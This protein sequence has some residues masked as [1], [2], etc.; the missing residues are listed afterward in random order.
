M[1]R[2]RRRLPAA[3]AVTFALL[4][5]AAM[6]A[7]LATALESTDTTL[8]D[9][10]TLDDASPSPTDDGTLE[11]T[12]DDTET[13]DDTVDTV[14]DTVEETSDEL[15]AS[16]QEVLAPEEEPSE[17]PSD[18]ASD[19]TADDEGTEDEPADE[20]AAS[21]EGSDT[22]G[23]GDSTQQ[24]DRPSDPAAEREARLRAAAAVLARYQNDLSPSTME[25][26]YG[27]PYGGDAPAWRMPVRSV[28]GIDPASVFIAGPDL[29]APLFAGLDY[30]RSHGQRS[31]HD[32]LERL[33]DAGADLSTAAKVLSPF[34]VVGPATYTDDWHYPRDG[35]DRLHK[36]T[37]IFAQRGTPVVASADGVIGRIGVNQ[38]L[39]GNTIGLY[40]DDGTYFYYAH[41]DA[42]A[43]D[44]RFNL[45]VE[46]GDIIGFVGDSGNAAGTPPHLHF[47]IH[48]DNGAAIPPVDHLDGWLEE[49]RAK[50]LLVRDRSG[51][52][53]LP[54]M[55][56]PPAAGSA[57]VAEGSASVGEGSA[58]ASSAEQL[59]TRR[60]GYTGHEDSSQSIAVFLALTGVAWYFLRRRSVFAGAGA[61]SGSEPDVVPAVPDVPDVLEPVLTVQDIVQAGEDQRSVSGERDVLQPVLA[62]RGAEPQ[63]QPRQDDGAR[64]D[65]LADI[66]S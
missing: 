16:T 35:G 40:A 32:I 50:V 30:D 39:G 66:L 22:E 52:D 46:Q 27:A 5:V 63:P 41:L 65:V 55:V 31:T 37:D 64:R 54:T 36:G 8:V 15:E 53:G 24:A 51:L 1:N 3:A 21:D 49:A 44:V 19:E 42:F 18:E 47:Q 17:D 38:G 2:L 43:A 48:P 6:A 57:D 28:D 62:G 13:V 58:D 11:S 61:S 45:R 25:A 56:A 29:S 26:M 23:A 33:A 20:P 4:I 10:T 7:P 60:T 12:V 9:D 14:E 34:P 59:A